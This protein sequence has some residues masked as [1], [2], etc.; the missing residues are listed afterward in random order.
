MKMPW[1]DVILFTYKA[2]V[3]YESVED[4]DGSSDRKHTLSLSV[5]Q[6]GAI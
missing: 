6:Y 3:R 2:D 5:C 4:M 1:C